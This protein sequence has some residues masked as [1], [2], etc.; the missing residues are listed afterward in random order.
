MVA[1]AGGTAGQSYF[2]ELVLHASLGKQPGHLPVTHAA[3]VGDR[4]DFRGNGAVVAVAVVA[5]G[6][7][8]I[9][10]F[11]HRLAVDAL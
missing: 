9:A 6:S 5:G 7:A 2:H 11:H 3:G 1:V 8:E 4:A 10:L